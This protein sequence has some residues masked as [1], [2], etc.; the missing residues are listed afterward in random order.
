MT[1]GWEHMRSVVVPALV[2]ASEGGRLPIVVD[3]SSCAEG[4][5]VMLRSAAEAGPAP[6]LRV[7]DAVEFAAELLPRLAVGRRIPSVALHPTCSG[8]IAGTV[9]QLAAIAA[10]IAD[11]VFTP[12]EAGC[13][14]FAGDRGL[15]HP[16]LTASATAPEAGGIEEA[17]RAR[18]G[19]FAE[20]ASSNRT[21]EIGLTRATARPYRHILEL[22]AEATR[23]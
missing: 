15:L 8:T 20:Y 12:A 18:G 1:S 10:H 7:V 13:C 9:P 17:E 6:A 5:A 2:E 21:C 16:E 14:A 22:L 11:E 4:L 3:A 23:P 19:R